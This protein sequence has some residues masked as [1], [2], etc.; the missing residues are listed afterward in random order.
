MAIPSP[1]GCARWA[2]RRRSASISNRRSAATCSPWRAWRSPRS[3]RSTTRRSARSSGGIPADLDRARRRGA[4]LD[5][6][7]RCGDA[8]HERSHRQPGAGQAGRYRGDVARPA[9]HVAGARCR[10][11]ASSCRARAPGC[12]T[13]WWPAASP[14]ATAGCCGP[15]S[16]A[17]RAKLAASG[18]RI[19]AQLDVKSVSRADCRAMNKAGGTP[20]DV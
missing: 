1:A 17:V 18:E 12:A 9:R 11:L 14:S 15:I 3:A 19:L 5:H 6:H 4:G 2:R 16:R 10:G 20:C 13:C 8:G 7:P